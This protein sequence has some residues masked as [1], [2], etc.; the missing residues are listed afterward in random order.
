MQPQAGPALQAGRQLGE[1]VAVEVEDDLQCLPAALDVVE[2]IGVC[3]RTGGAGRV[4]TEAWGSPALPWL[5]QCQTLLQTPTLVSWTR[6]PA[7]STQ[8]GHLRSLC[9]PSVRVLAWDLQVCTPGS[10]VLGCLCRPP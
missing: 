6:L 10:D 5:G 3:G 7:L 2:D 1:V 9:V 8:M 4:T